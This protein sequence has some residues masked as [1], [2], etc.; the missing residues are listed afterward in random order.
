M[1]IDGMVFGYPLAEILLHISYL[2]LVAGSL[3]KMILTFRVMILVSTVAGMVSGYLTGYQSMVLWEAIFFL[4]NLVQVVLLTRERH[5]VHL[6]EEERELHRRK[7]SAL[8][9]V[10]FYRLARRGTWIAAVP[11]ENL[12]IQGFPVVRILVLSQGAAQVEIDGTKV[13]LCKYGDFIGEM[14]FVSGNTASATV[15][16]VADSRYLMWSAQE[17][18]EL[19]LK[20]PDIMSALQ[21]VF[22]KNLI[23][24][25]SRVVRTSDELQ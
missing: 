1:V 25:L 15:T 9:V 24:K 2:M 7:F 10:D 19:L 20:Y 22:S 12:T 17:L 11:G 21:T 14:A 4:V 8:S 6:T 5:S 13:A 18:K 16:T 3:V 23:E